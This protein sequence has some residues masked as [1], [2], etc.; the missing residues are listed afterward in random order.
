MGEKHTATP[1]QQN[2]SNPKQVCDASN[3]LGCA[4]IATFKRKEDAEFCVRACNAHDDLVKA[5]EYMLDTC[6]HLEVD[7]PGDY[8]FSNERAVLA[9]ALAKAGAA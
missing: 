4:P 9:A 5:L 6:G 8:D 2:D 3:E 7:Y 1:W